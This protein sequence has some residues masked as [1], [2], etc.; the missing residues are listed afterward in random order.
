MDRQDK[1]SQMIR[2]SFPNFK[3]LGKDMMTAGACISRMDQLKKRW[4]EFE[5]NH[6]KLSKDESV[7]A[8]DEY[9]KTGQYD[10]IY[11]AF[12][13]NMGLFQDQL[14][15]VK[16]ET[17]Q[18]S[19]QPGVDGVIAEMDVNRTKLPQIVINDFSGDIQD[20]VR[21]RDTFKEMVIDRP[22]LPNIFKMNYLR[23][24]VK[25]EAAELLQEVPSGGE[26]F[27]TAW[28]VLL[29]HYDNRRLLVNK[30]MKKLMALPPMANE[31]ATELMRVLNGV[32]NLLQAL[33]ALGSPVD[34]WDH[35]TVF[36]TRSKITQKCQSKWEDNVKQVGN[37][38]EP[39]TFADLC[40]FL[41]AE[42]NALSLLESTKD[43]TNKAPQ[44]KNELKAATTS[45]GRKSNNFV[46]AK[47][48]KSACPVCS[49]AH[50]IE[51]CS[52]FRRQSV[53]ERRQTLGRKRLCYNC[54]G[55]HM[56]KDCKSNITCYMCNGKH[57]TLI[58]APSKKSG[59]KSSSE[60]KDGPASEALDSSASTSQNVLAVAS[61]RVCDD[62]LEALLA[63]ARV[64]VLSEEGQSATV[65]ALVD[66]CAQSSFITEE[67]CQRLRLKKRQVNVPISGIGQGPAN[68]RSEVEIAIRPHFKSQFELT[69]KAYVLPVITSYRPLCKSPEDWPHI[70]GLQLADPHFARPGRIDV[71]LSTQIHAL[72][73]REGLKTGDDTSPIAMKSHLGWILS[74]SA[75]RPGQGGTIVCLQVDDKLND[76]LKS[77]WEVEEPPHVLPWS[78]E[79]KQCEEHFKRNTVRLP[80]GRYQVRLPLKCGAPV[81]WLDS[82]QI[83]KSC[84]LSLERKFAK[85]P[86]L[87]A[88]YSSALEQMI[89][90]DQM[91]KIEIAPDSYDSHYFMPHHAVVKDSSTTTRV[92]PVFNAS[93]R[94]AAGSSLNE[95]LMTGPNLLPQLVSVVARW[96]RY[97]IAFAADVSKMYLQVRIH[98]ED[99]KLQTIL[100]RD[101]PRKEIEHYALTTVTFGS[102]PS[103]FL[104]NRTLRQLADDEEDRF[105]LASPIVRNEMYM[106]DVLSGAFDVESAIRKRDQLSALL[107]AGG[108]TLAKWMTNDAELLKSLNPD[109]LAKEATLK[110]G[111]GFA[112]LGLVWEP[113]SDVFRFNVMLKP[114]VNPITKRKVLS[115]I[116]G[117]FD[118]AGWISPVL[119]T[120]KIFMQSLWLLTKEWDAPLPEEES[121]KWR[122]FEV[123]LRQ[124]P[125]IT[126]PRWLGTTKEAYLEM[127][128]FADAS[129]LAYAA[130]LYVRIIQR[131]R[132]KVVLLASKT[133]VAPLKTLSIPRLELCAA[134]LL[135]KLAASFA[136]TADFAQANLH[137]W[138]D[139]RNTLH[140]IH[141]I[142][143]RWPVFVANRCADIV[144]HV[145]Q[146]C[147]HYV[148]TR[149]NPADLASRGCTV[150]DLLCDRLWWQGPE[151]LSLTA[152][153]WVSDEADYT[154]CVPEEDSSSECVALTQN[155]SAQQDCEFFARFS[156]YPRMQRV[157]VYCLRFVKK[158]TSRRGISVKLPFE[159]SDDDEINVQELIQA[160]LQLCR[161]AQRTALAYEL[162]CI[163]SNSPLS[164]RHYLAKLCPIS[165][166]GLLRVGG[167]LSNALIPEDQKHP[168]ILPTH[169]RLVTLLI[170]NMHRRL[171][172][173]GVSL[174]VMH[175]RQR[176]WI[177]KVKITVSARLRKCVVCLRYRSVTSSQRM[178]DLP[179]ARVTPDR[180]FKSAG[181]D[182]AGPFRL[183]ASRFRGEFS[184]KGY[185]A[186]FVCMVTKAIH[187]EAVSSYDADSFIA[188]FKRFT[189]RRGRCFHLYSDQGTNFVGADAELRRLHSKGSEAYKSICANL[190]DEH[191]TTWH[192]N[193]PSSPHFGGLWES[194]VK[195]VKHHLKRMVGD[196]LLTYEEF[197]TLLT[198]IEAILNSRPLTELGE[199]PKN[200]PV[201]TPAHQ[202]IQESSFI[203]AEPP[204]RKER[205]GPLERWKRITQL[206]QVFWDR[207]SQEYLH[208][209][210]KRNKWMSPKQNISV[211]DVVLIKDEVTP[212]A[213]WPMA[214]VSQL[215]PGRD[216]LVRVV[217]VTTAKGSYKRPVVKI[218][219][220]IDHEE[221]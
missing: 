87:R 20:W 39:D 173:G 47:Q 106:D 130:V 58:H 24:Y 19:A 50:T 212:C 36:L 157:L 33:K 189:A 137:L 207:W 126:I 175:L 45:R 26:H 179:A 4:Q 10:I 181:L 193:P 177:P 5:S 132:V 150:S 195:S 69:F 22:N 138:S 107:S 190:R 113:Q 120:L 196:A 153:P 170:D 61:S 220:L 3:K 104:A 2:N 23:T 141:G 78:K 202:L 59:A 18:L 200:D 147:W 169:S 28:R 92:R 60:D 79:D 7:S 134:H 131:G 31:T 67:L 186:V 148:N 182:Y 63:T 221:C 172:H 9:F 21:F 154:Q 158:L 52:K 64:Q 139:S 16:R 83:A 75:E 171:F 217:T 99:W 116:A 213:R 143:A 204:I 176:F 53:G 66:Q 76:Q 168:I 206:T 123:D 98:P 166:D 208:T 46:Q 8:E 151:M 93:A 146:A 142:P 162:Q 13:T 38:V 48:E 40:K 68:S 144:Q 35:F 55:A 103:A 216:G 191:G 42:R 161:M 218:V 125:S 178:A 80:D 101:D 29:S 159:P 43:Y 82:R 128:G 194:G 81:N 110:V 210:Q 197:A 11:E 199:D 90:S 96:R 192:F 133:K 122:A 56:M 119:I 37:S 164:K 198:Q 25:G 57:H 209:L 135:A 180:C 118:P 74:G 205:F 97:P 100:W 214:R 140:W 54:L 215:H 124:L 34:H 32:R 84:L 88:E 102:G 71:L 155:V 14:L 51:Q 65:R 94:N 129:K 183:K 109:T 149:Q 121:E 114:L 41:E 30:L 70:K 156:S 89:R 49:E 167:R 219:K 185:L 72:I 91:R 17:M 111:L 115:S 127:H 27:P 184:Y 6:N 163:E 77:F 15:H 201:L 44:D 117:M 73:M 112:V 188:A 152:R 105:P 136:A 187:L 86:S 12:L 95:H 160:E 1:L 211:G 108:F 85:N 62:R 174:V 203:V 145:P 165:V